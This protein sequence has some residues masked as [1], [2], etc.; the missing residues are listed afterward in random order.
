MSK[1]WAKHDAE[2]DRLMQLVPATL[3]PEVDRF[4]VE[5]C[6]AEHHYLFYDN[7]H[8][9]RYCTRCRKSIDRRYILAPKHN[10]RIE[11]PQC[12]CPLTAVCIGRFKKNRLRTDNF[13]L[14]V[15]Q[16]TQEGILVR[17][18]S[19]VR[20]C[21][22]E[23]GVV[24]EEWHWR[25]MQ[26]IF[27]DGTTV[28]RYKLFDVFSPGTGWGTEWR[29]SKQL[30]FATHN[31][32]G[33]VTHDAEYD[34]V[35]NIREIIAGTCWQYSRLA[36][37]D[38]FRIRG[39][40]L[41][42]F[43][44]WIRPVEYLEK[45]GWDA[46]ARDIIGFDTR[47]LR[48]AAKTIEQIMRLPKEHIAY[49]RKHNLDN[50]ELQA[51]RTLIRLKEPIPDIN[52]FRRFCM[53]GHNFTFCQSLA[54]SMRLAEWMRYDPASSHDYLYHD[55][56]RFCRDLGYDMADRSILFPKDLKKAH[57]REMVRVKTLAKQKENEAIAKRYQRDL[58]RYGFHAACFLI[59]PPVDAEE[60]I[61]EGAKLHHCVGSYIDKVAKGETTILLVRRKDKPEAPYFTA[62]WQAGRLVQI[63]GDHN[64]P[65]TPE[66]AEFIK[67]WEARAKQ[68]PKPKQKV[69]ALA[70][71]A[72]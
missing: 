65:P 42:Y 23:R 2:R 68:K 41:S 50:S 31:N 67:A 34:F 58:T 64:N 1:N 22:K 38:D 43:A 3:P 33:W 69:A 56:L 16:R 71:A 24:N 40:V 60:I 5:V 59:R 66:V 72:V 27:N 13:N 55:Y 25:E 8:D 53:Y 45:T 57:D 26:R 17:L 54:P 52:A 6:L 15:M 62:E 20:A 4:L 32:M 12:G 61:R 48:P 63:R 51:L 35:A 70:A 7:R 30:D 44:G 18:F 28:K 11:C 19:L 14:R 47:Y 46:L 37:A 39:G 29:E 36:K 21:V 10:Q 49:A 9:Y